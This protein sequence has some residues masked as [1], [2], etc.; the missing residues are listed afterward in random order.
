M[1]TQHTT[2]S[3]ASVV[4]LTGDISAADT[5]RLRG[6]AYKALASS[7]EAHRHASASQVQL[8]GATGGDRQRDHAGDLLVD[9][10]A[11][12]SFDDAAMAALSS[13]RTRARHL[14]AQL[15]VIDQ[16]DGA[17]SLSLRRTGLAFRF[18]RFESVEAATASMEQARSARARLD[19]PLEAEWRAAR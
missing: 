10:S 11:V 2:T 3:D 8:H 14:G 7:A 17:L 4:T 16:V 15:V 19:M 1:R 18:P 5:D 13:A 9:A 6:A 12:T